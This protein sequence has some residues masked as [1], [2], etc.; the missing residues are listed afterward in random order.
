MEQLNLLTGETKREESIR[1]LREHE[2][3]EGYFLGFSGGKDS[4]VT[5]HLA[6]EAGVKF[7]AY[8]SKTGIDAPEVVHFIRDHYPDVI[9]C[10][11][12]E[13]FFRLIPKK[14]YPSMWARWCCDKIKK[15]NTKH[16][17]L[18]KRL[19][20]IRA[21]ES[22]RRAKR[23]RIDIFNKKQTIYK[24]IF[25]WLEW[26]IWEYIESN[27]IP[28]CSLYDEGFNRLGCV[29]CPFVNGKKLQINKERWPKIYAAF[30]K[31]MRK[32]WDK[33]KSNGE[34]WHESTFEEFLSN[35][36]KGK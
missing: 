3:P 33:G 31:A 26:E 5:Y 32:L 18:K 1:F 4:Q 30:E 9:H 34:S 10:R 20:G 8:Y 19:M 29:V 28:Y 22:S 17:P 21:E 23:P 24:P 14:G 13:S 35:W 11:P 25:T 2:P 12:K 15:E 36:Y 16:I 7:Q 27:G 6:L